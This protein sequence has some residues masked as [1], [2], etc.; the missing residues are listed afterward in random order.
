MKRTLNL[1]LVA[2]ALAASCTKNVNNPDD[3]NNGNSTVITGDYIITKYSDSNP[4]EDNTADFAGYVFTFSDD[5]KITASKNGVS[6]QG[7]YTETPSHEGEAAKLTINFNDAPLN[8]LNKKWQIDLISD[9][10]IHLSDDDN[11]SEVLEFTAQ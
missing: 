10:A 3:N 9:A 1:L 8:E 7:S 6:T 4:N 11:A 2:L 5:G